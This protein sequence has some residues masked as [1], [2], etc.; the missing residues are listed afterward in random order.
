MTKLPI[1]LT[2]ADY[3]RVMPLAIGAV[4]PDGIDL[5]LLLGEGG[6]WAARA[7]MLRR[8]LHDPAVEGGEQSMAGHLIRIDKGDRSHV[9]LPVFP[10]RNFTARDLYIA[11]DGPIRSVRDLA[12]GRIGMYGWANSGSVWY[13]H[14]LSY[15]GL[16]IGKLRWWIGAIDQPLAGIGAIGLPEGVSQ[17]APGRSLSEMLLAGELDAIYSPPRPVAYHP[18]KGPIVRL[19]PEFRCLEQTYFRE[20]GAFP[21]QH[22]IV[23]RRATWEANKWIARSITEAF[24]RCNDE[25]TAAQRGF[26][27]ATPWLEAELE[28]ITALMGDNFHSYGIE[29]NRRQMEIFCRTAFE[30]G[31]TRRL[32]TVEEYFQEYLDS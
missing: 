11:K 28:E 3:A 1:T 2:S 7:E 8:A 4:K 13:R 6:S 26:P 29:P 9:G 24:V 15:V 32:I 19:F 21:P 10:L 30:A 5:T 16:D 23:I 18:G 17:P 31:L 25:F 27:Y 14:F 12:G 20:T 22:L